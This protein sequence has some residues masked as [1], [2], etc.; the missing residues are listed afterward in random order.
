MGLGPRCGILSTATSRLLMS[1]W[2]W[3]L[4]RI[5]RSIQG[6]SRLAALS[7]LLFQER[8]VLEARIADALLGLHNHTNLD[9]GWELEL[10]SVASSKDH[11]YCRWNGCPSAG[12]VSAQAKPTPAITAVRD[13]LRKVLAD[14]AHDAQ[15]GAAE[16]SGLRA[17][18]AQH[19]IETIPI[20]TLSG[21][22]GV[23][24][25]CCLLHP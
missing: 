24:F 25:E 17:P 9:E 8:T 19:D 14:H 3:A 7:A 2:N 20:A 1:R 5:R 4:L 13:V 6:Y 16:L 23:L 10:D 18:V 15:L 11:F 21:F 22:V 12:L